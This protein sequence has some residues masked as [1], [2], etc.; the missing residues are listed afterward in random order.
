[1]PLSS[2]RA[3]VSSTMVLAP[4]CTSFT[5]RPKVSDLFPG[6]LAGRK[7]EEEEHAH[8]SLGYF[9]GAAPVTTASNWPELYQM[10]TPV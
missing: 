3:E 10:A 9:L 7:D 5:S 8:S 4:Q 1:M 6:S 2:T